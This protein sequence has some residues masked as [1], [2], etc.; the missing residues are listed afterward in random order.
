MISRLVSQQ[1]KRVASITLTAS[2]EGASSSLL[3]MEGGE[4]HRL[5]QEQEQEQEYL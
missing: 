1:Q 4:E 2:Q 5:E 3:V